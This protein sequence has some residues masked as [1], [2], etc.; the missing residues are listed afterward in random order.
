MITL[1][2]EIKL[3][4]SPEELFLFL[5]TL[6]GIAKCFDYK[7]VKQLKIINN[8]V[9]FI[10]RNAAVFKF[11]IGKV[12]DEYVQIESMKE[13]PFMTAIR[14]EIKPVAEGS[15]VNVSLETDT[16]PIMDFTFEGKAK[17]WVSAIVENLEKEFN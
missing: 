16:S 1:S 3:K 8:R 17:R 14:F 2:T 12:T 10:L 15:F 5:G 7:K 6:E 11:K 9:E 13:V 4:S